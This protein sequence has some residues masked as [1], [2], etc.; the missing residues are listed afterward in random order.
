M[1]RPSK[2]LEMQSKHLTKEEIE[3]RSQAESMLKSSDDKVYEP[4]VGLNKETQKIYKEMVEK[5]RP[6]NILSNLDIDL[7]SVTSD[8]LYP[9]EVARRDIEKHGQVI[10]VEN[11]FGAI[12]KAIKNPSVEV[13]RAYENIFRSSCGQLCLSPSARAKLSAEIALSLK[14]ENKNSKNAELDWLIGG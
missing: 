9:M 10:H 6:L 8:A 1:A 2:P 7:L 11:E 13:F 5:L 14:E 4:P 3:S 12:V